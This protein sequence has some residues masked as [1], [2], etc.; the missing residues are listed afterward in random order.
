[1]SLEAGAGRRLARYLVQFSLLLLAT[2]LAQA[3]CTGSASLEHSAVGITKHFTAEE[4]KADPALLGIRGTG[5]FLSQQ[6]LVT[7]AH[8]AQSMRL[9]EESWTEIEMTQ[10]SRHKDLP[11][12][13]RNVVGPDVEKIAIIELKDGFPGAEPLRIRR[14][15]LTAG[16]IVFSLGYPGNRLRIASGR[17]VK[18]G[19]EMKLAGTALF[20][21]WE[22]DDRL[23]L[24]HGASGAPVIDCEGRAVAVVSDVFTKTISFMS[25]AIRVSTAWGS[26]NVVAVPVTVLED[27]RSPDTR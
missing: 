18:D 5:W 11:I 14:D 24:D 21:L 1:M 10:G 19:D 8:V 23:A 26:P 2:P 6:L 17:F 4:K 13:L 16:E 7:V 22:G 12:R 9:S 3:A 20:E 15:T 27:A 25:Q